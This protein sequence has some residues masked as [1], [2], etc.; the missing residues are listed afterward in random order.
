MGSMI[1][2]SKKEIDEITA[3]YG[4]RRPMEM[5]V[6]RAQRCDELMN[7]VNLHSTHKMDRLRGESDSLFEKLEMVS[8]KNVMR[9][10]FSYCRDQQGRAVKSF[11]QVAIDDK[12]DII[13]YEGG[14]ESRVTRIDPKTIGTGGRKKRNV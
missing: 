3:R 10:G 14:L 6:Q 13:L 1:E 9:R 8:P 11:K 2:F 7:L 5:I 4:F 12:I